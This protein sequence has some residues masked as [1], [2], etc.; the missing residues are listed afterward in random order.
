MIP[1]L[2]KTIMQQS[3][4]KNIAVNNVSFFQQFSTFALL[5]KATI[6]AY[7]KQHKQRDFHYG[8]TIDTVHNRLYS[9]DYNYN[10]LRGS[11]VICGLSE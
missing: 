10:P 5:K 6:N 9:F 3:H 11:N 8:R 2:A 4:P 7:S 1:S